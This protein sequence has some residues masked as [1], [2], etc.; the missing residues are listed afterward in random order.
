MTREYCIYEIMC[1]QYSD[2][3]V[4]AVTSCKRHMDEK[5][6]PIWGTPWAR[7]MKRRSMPSSGE[8]TRLHRLLMFGQCTNHRS[9]LGACVLPYCVFSSPLPQSHMPT[10]ALP[11]RT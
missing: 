6:W 8:M 7:T 11:C 2:K 9:I 10:C 1:T 5:Q 4:A 3:K